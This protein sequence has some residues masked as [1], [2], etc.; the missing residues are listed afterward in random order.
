MIIS[1]L[2]E[3]CSFEISF[4]R[5]AQTI[6][7]DTQEI[8]LLTLIFRRRHR[9]LRN[10]QKIHYYSLPV[11]IHSFLVTCCKI[12]RSTLQNLL[13]TS[14]KILSLLVAGVSHCKNHLLFVA[15]YTRYS[16]LKLLVANN[17]Q[18]LV[19][20]FTC[21]RCN[22]SLI[23]CCRSFL[24]EK[25]IRYSFKQSEVK[26]KFQFFQYNLFPKPK[27]KKLYQVNI[28]CCDLLLGEH[29]PTQQYT[30]HANR[31]KTQQVVT[32]NQRN[33]QD[34]TKYSSYFLI[35]AR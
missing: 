21:T 35:C 26:V 7:N 8:L 12:T 1:T 14:C 18:L 33:K 24:L 4:S 32:L 34:L 16:F 3:S 2:V 15:K 31:K 19:A 29:C 11:E 27:N 5:R 28:F 6:T 30:Q 17:D 13:V 20:K 9:K 25:I 10:Y 23:P 22:K